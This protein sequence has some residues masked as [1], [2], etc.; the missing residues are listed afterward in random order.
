MI[1]GTRYAWSSWSDGG[2]ISHTVTAATSP[3]T[4]TANFNTQYL[5]TLAAS[6]GA[7]GSVAANP[8]SSDGYY[9]SGTSVQVT[10]TANSGFQFANFSGDLTGATNPQS[11]SMTAPRSVTASFNV[12]TTVATNPSGLAITVDGQSFTAPKTFNWAP[13][14]GHAIAVATPQNGPAGTHYVWSNWSDAGA[15]SHSITTASSATTY[16]ANFNTQFL[17]TLAAAPSGGG[18][19]TAN[20]TSSDGYYA[21]GAP[22]QVTA[23]ANSGFQFANF[24]GDLSGSTNPQSVTMTVPRSVTATFNAQT[25]VTTNPPGLSITVDGQSFTAP[26]TF[27]WVTGTAHTIAVASPQNGSAGMRSAWSNW[28]DGAA[29]SHT[30]TAAATATTYTASFTTQYLL[31]RS[32][33]PVGG[34]TL[35]ANPASSD[36]FYASGTSV[37][38]TAASNPGF[39]FSN[40]SGD[41]TGSV[42]PQSVV[43]S[44]PRSVT[45]NF[46]VQSTVT[47]NPPGRSITVDGQSFTAPQTFNWAPGS[48]HTIATSTPQSAGAGTRYAWSNWSDGGALSHTITANSSTTYTANFTTQYLLAITSSPNN[49][50]TLTAN[51]ASS[52]GYY[53]SGA[54][55]QVTASPNSGFQFG[56]FSGDLSGAANP[57][58]VVLSAPRSVTGSFTALTG[59]VVGTNPPGLGFTVDGISFTGA[60]NFSWVPGSVHTLAVNSP[61]SGTAGTR[62]AWANWSD[63]GAISHTITATSTPTTYTASFSAQY[64]LTLAASPAGGGSLAANPT[65]PDGYY[66]GSTSVQITATANSGFLFTGFSG[67]LSGLDESA[68]HRDDRSSIGNRQLQRTLDAHG[69]SLQAQLWKCDRPH[70]FGTNRSRRH[71]AGRKLVR[72]VESAEHHRVSQFGDWQRNIYRHGQRRSWRRDHGEFFG[73]VRIAADSSQH[74]ARYARRALRQF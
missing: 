60:Q 4:Y 35:T 53:N 31:T 52:D 14:S 68:I 3:S 66:A 46:N 74:H 6:P 42:N 19:L 47:T 18:T 71:S 73:R 44:A 62:Y 41:L 17:L 39:Q 30:V 34:G 33:A 63:G 69:G 2:A 22:V 25:T 64:L 72:F 20:P 37:Q 51:P 40:F 23:A 65:S 50:G 27:S 57:Q 13:G 5:L 67:D 7:G 54:S 11:V 29:I 61:Q 38:I 36:G 12:Q 16:T 21:S 48:N 49:G 70:Y 32:A 59:V 10:A 15:I 8:S 56:T 1:A 26:Q 55:V 9:G 28:S 24:S 43:L 58:T 45:G